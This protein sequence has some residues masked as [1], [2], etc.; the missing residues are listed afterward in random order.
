MSTYQHLAA[1]GSSFAAGP[2]IPPMVDRAAGRSGRNYPHL[3]AERLGARLTDLTISGATT[4]TLLS[5]PQ[6][7]W[8][9]LPKRFPP[10]VDGVPADADLITVTAR[11]NDLDYIGGLGRAALAGRLQSWPATRWLGERLGRRGVPQVA[12]ADAERAIEGLCTVV[13][14]ARQRAPGARIVL[15]DY[16]AVVGPDSRPG[17]EL[18]LSQGDIEAVRQVGQRLAEVFAAAAERSGATL[19]TFDADHA[20]GSAHPWVNGFSLRGP[21]PFHPNAD[22]MRAVADEVHRVVTHD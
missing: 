16:L 15:V 13:G 6:R 21:A 20:L 10:Q 7:R 17:P 22:G 3:L 5:Q 1:I 4:Q 12:P 2:G 18:P 19:V 14:A 11:G 9:P 8:S